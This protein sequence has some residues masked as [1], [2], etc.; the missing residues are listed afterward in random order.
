MRDAPSI[1]DVNNCLHSTSFSKIHAFFGQVYLGSNSCFTIATRDR[2]GCAH[3]FQIFHVHQL[4][5][6]P[7]YLFAAMGDSPGAS[8]IAAR[9]C[10]SSARFCRR[11]T[12]S[13][14][15]SRNPAEAV[16]QYSRAKTT[17]EWPETRIP[18]RNKYCLRL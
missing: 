2:D 3:D 11:K 12:L 4:A 1:K 18:P 8:P 13:E 6:R 15:A 17:A 7:L 14:N 10:L 9:K 5:V 16:V